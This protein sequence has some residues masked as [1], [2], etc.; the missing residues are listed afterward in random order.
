MRYSAVF[1]LALACPLAARGADQPLTLQAA[2]DFAL[3]R[4]PQITAVQAASE[5]A[6]ALAESAGR[7]PDPQAIVGVDNLP[8]T[9]PDAYSTSRDFMTMRRIGVMQAFP[10]GAQR[11]SE[12][13]VA[14]AQITLADAELDA[15]RYAVAR[16]TAEAWVRYA[17]TTDSLERLRTLEEDMELGARAATAALKSGRAST[18]EALAADAS[19]TGLKSRV[20]QLRVII[21]SV[22]VLLGRRPVPLLR[23][24]AR[25]R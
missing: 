16:A 1:F 24:A 7:L 18:S 17:T 14:A 15:T 19:V 4:A 10:A 13:T 12:R 21:T 9:G 5:S 2:V 25:R 8:V 11:R 22:V 20:L 23:V 6:H 3:A